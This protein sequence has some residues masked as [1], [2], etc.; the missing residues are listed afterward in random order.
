MSQEDNLIDRLRTP[1]TRDHAFRDLVITYQERLYWHI[2]KFVFDHEDANDILQNTLIKA[3]R[4]LD[5]FKGDAKLYT[6]LYRIA[7]NESITF[8]NKAKRMS[9][10]SLDAADQLEADA[11]FD[12]DMAQIMLQKALA[13]LPEKQRLVFNMKYYEDLSYQEI[14]DILE[15]SVGALKA[16]FHHAVKKIEAYFKNVQ[17]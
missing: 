14:S 9:S 3:Y 13:R 10:G 6:W 12:G 7:S 8:V 15:T 16:S 17:V 2:R 1:K 4:G 11:F 5:G